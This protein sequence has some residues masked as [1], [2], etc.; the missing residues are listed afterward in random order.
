MPMGILVVRID[1]ILT[2][3]QRVEEGRESEQEL[4]KNH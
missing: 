3:K 4:I 1:W 2:L